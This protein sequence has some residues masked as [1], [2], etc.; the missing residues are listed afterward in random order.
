MS[1]ETDGA[2]EVIRIK[3]RRLELLEQQAARQGHS[4]D[5]SVT[6]EIEDLRAEIPQLE[7]KTAQAVSALGLPSSL[8]STTGAG[9][10]SP[11]V[12]PTTG[13]PVVSANQAPGQ[14]IQWPLAQ[15]GPAVVLDPPPIQPWVGRRTETVSGLVTEAQ[16]VTWYALNG[17]ASRGKTLLTRLLADALGGE[18][19]W[20]GFDGLSDESAA[21]LLER[22]CS[23]LTGQAPPLRRN[24]WYQAA[25]LTL[26]SGTVLVLDDLPNLASAPQLVSRLVAFIRAC[27]SAGVRV[28]SSSLFPL[29]QSVLEELGEIVT[30]EAAPPF[31]DSDA[32]EVLAAFDAPADMVDSTARFIN[33]LARQHPTL[34]VAACRYLQDRNWQLEGD[35]LAG[36]FQG[37]Y[38]TNLA[39]EVHQKLLSTIPDEATRQLLY[40]LTLVAGPFSLE[41]VDVLAGAPPPITGARARLRDIL[42]S[43]VEQRG[44]GQCVVSALVVN[45]GRENLSGS[46][47]RVCHVALGDA[48]VARGSVNQHQ[49]FL[50]ITNYHMG[51]EYGKS[52][53]MLVMILKEAVEHA[54][55][56][57]EDAL[58][59]LWTRDPL[60]AEFNLNLRLMV[61][62]LHIALFH[63]LDRDLRFLFDDF[64]AVLA[65]A[66]ESH[67]FGIAGAVSFIAMSIGRKYPLESG[68]WLRRFLQLPASAS[69]AV[70]P[71][72]DEEAEL[73]SY[74]LSQELPLFG[75]IWML[76]GELNTAERVNDWLD[77]FQAMPLEQRNQAI[78][79][80][81]SYVSC[82]VV[83]DSLTGGEQAKPPGERN[84]PVQ[85]LGPARLMRRC[86]ARRCGGHDAVVHAASVRVHATRDLGASGTLG[87]VRGDLLDPEVREAA[88][89]L[90]PGDGG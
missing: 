1:T 64:E 80:D 76:V 74:T 84:W 11:F 37:T 16:D 67:R 10:A 47:R 22:V 34:L 27:A 46:E 2:L 62:G 42:N 83:G 58:L 20:V 4:V 28:L 41:E 12:P 78:A 52:A 9:T 24:P 81:Q 71:E 69:P 70:A 59:L 36:L 61:R 38:A 18:L 56:V 43:W 63:K 79:F 88:I 5:P 23:N 17:I 60:P 13:S 29:P 33:A 82:V 44:D 15:Q 26:G 77:T 39:A 48:V 54:E 50:A 30:D 75:L 66:D 85:D 31:T 6:M 53:T 32:K 40:R 25:A 51:E 89:S 57:Q 7:Q 45:M 21:S 14:D 19:S 35:A 86:F 68:R 55:W 87:P 49:A 73:E 90:R 8:M 72:A 65:Q 3:K